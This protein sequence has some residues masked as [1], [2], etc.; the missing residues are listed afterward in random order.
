MSETKT[1]T[2]DEGVE[3][4]EKSVT[5]THS[6]RLAG[7]IAAYSVTVSTTNLKDEAGKDRAS[8]FSVA[9][10]L[11]G[12]KDR[13][14][15]PV[16]FCFN[17][18]PGSSAVWLQFGALGPKRIDIPDV[19]PAPPPP[20]RLIDN[21]QGILDV[22]DMVF[23]DPVGTGFSRAAGKTEEKE[24]F[25]VKEDVESIC[26]FI[27]RWLTK[28][29]RWNSPKLLAGESYGTTRAGGIARQLADDGVALS[30]LVLISLA[31]NFQTFIAEPGNDLPYVLYLPS[32]AAVAAYHGVVEEQDLDAVRQ[33]AIEEYAPALMYGADLSEE[34]KGALAQRLSEI[35]GLPADE[36]ARR[37]LR[38]P[39]LWFA[40]TLL[41]KTDKT[42]GRLD[43]RYVGPDLDPYSE[44][45]QRDP[46][47]DAALSAYT[48][49]VN[50]F[51]RSEC[52]WESDELYRVLSM[53]VNKGWK[54]KTEGRLGFVNTTEDLRLAMVANPHMK[55]LV[56]NGI[57]DLA[58][59]FFAAEHTMRHLG[60]PDELRSN[61][62]L[63]YYD[64]GHM[65][66]FHP[67]SL[68]K[69]RA[70]LAYFYGWALTT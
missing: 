39:Y 67:P 38:I 47:Y 35:T 16:T 8:V 27:K 45:M 2:K 18:G 57:Y 23:I 30:G 53:D 1:E 22:T 24:F 33:F 34:H 25:A 62:R 51:L 52:S 58:T 60:A 14:T 37:K 29:D 66:Y 20:H 46:S 50:A 68:R 41:G 63:T 15:R 19:A 17:G 26:E 7:G 40:R 31:T 43:G 44:L 65:M 64:A 54:W 21:P 10:V 59:P 49:S 3:R 61:V 13:S 55:V 42:V 56:A 5:T 6:A 9:Y 12:V 32:L 69:L 70:D 48:A 11:D 4:P 28:N 36:I